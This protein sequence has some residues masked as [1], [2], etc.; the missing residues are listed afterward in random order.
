MPFI[1]QFNLFFLFK[2][3][4]VGLDGQTFMLPL[5]CF[6]S[7]F[8]QNETL[9]FILYPWWKWNLHSD[10]TEVEFFNFF[11]CFLFTIFSTIIPYMLK[12]SFYFYIKKK[13]YLIRFKTLIPKIYIFLLLWFLN[14]YDDNLNANTS[15]I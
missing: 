6:L 15:T 7:F 12:S 11:P 1:V 2:A 3:A 4:K 5:T 9:C 14:Y 8:P 13:I 10:A